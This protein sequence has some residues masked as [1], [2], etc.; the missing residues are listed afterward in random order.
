MTQSPAPI[1]RDILTRN[2]PV[3]PDTSTIGDARE[4]LRD[5]TRFATINYIYLVDS[6]GHLSGTLSIK[7]TFTHREET[8]IS[9]LMTRNPIS[10]HE[11]TRQEKVARIALD[12]NLKAIPI[13]DKEGI[14]RGVASSDTILRILDQEMHE[15][16]LRLGGHTLTRDPLVTTANES[17]RHAILSRMPWLIVGCLGGTII[18]VIIKNFEEAFSET[19]L[20]A[21]FIPL[22]VYIASAISTQLSTLI[23]RDI[24]IGK[25]PSLSPYIAKQFLISVTVGSILAIIIE[26]ILQFIPTETSTRHA[27]SLGVLGASSSAVLTGVLI[28]SFFHRLRIDPAVATGPVATIIQDMTSVVIFLTIAQAIIG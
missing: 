4:L 6:G 27:V 12:H 26:L 3:L 19:L 11:H 14:L 7:E 21:S 8:P 9:R 24:A 5:A 16:I 1:A 17:L 10:V 28:P 2:I 20:V 15:D 23:I 22:V 13:I 18:S 25:L